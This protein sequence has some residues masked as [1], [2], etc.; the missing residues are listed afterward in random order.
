MKL[1]SILWTIFPADDEYLE[2]SESIPPTLAPTG[3]SISLTNISSSPDLGDVRITSLPSHQ[4]NRTSTVP[5]P[6]E[7]IE[8]ADLIRK[9]VSSLNSFGHRRNDYVTG[10]IGYQLQELSQIEDKTFNNSNITVEQTSTPS[11]VGTSTSASCTGPPLHSSLNKTLSS[12]E[13]T[14]EGN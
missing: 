7:G 11:G 5:P 14:K 12:S 6:H 3:T 9:C 8:K 13:N 1:F 2:E 4:E 10:M